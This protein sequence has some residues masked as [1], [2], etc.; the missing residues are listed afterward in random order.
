ML[1]EDCGGLAGFTPVNGAGNEGLCC[2]T[3]WEYNPLCGCVPPN[4]SCI[5]DSGGG[6]Y[7][8]C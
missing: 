3:G 5:Q 1:G 4:C 6:V 7:G 8:I 2:P